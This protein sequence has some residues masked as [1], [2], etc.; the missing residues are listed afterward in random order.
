MIVWSKSKKQKQK[1][2]FSQI[3]GFFGKVG[4]GT[5]EHEKSY[6]HNLYM[7]WNLK[8]LTQT[9]YNMY[10]NHVQLKNAQALCDYHFLFIFPS[11]TWTR[12]C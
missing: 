9:P 7:N 11:P 2:S 4:K 8:N 3:M 10:S 12:K 6:H 1:Q 5:S